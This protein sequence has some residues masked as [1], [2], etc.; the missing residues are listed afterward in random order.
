MNIYKLLYKDFAN[1][2]LKNVSTLIV[3]GKQGVV[4]KN[5]ET[6]CRNST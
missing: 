1:C 6:N 2:I 4:K 5:I 3:Q